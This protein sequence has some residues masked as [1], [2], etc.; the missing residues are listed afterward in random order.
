MLPSLTSQPEERDKLLRRLEHNA[1]AREHTC[2][3]KG[4][5]S[6]QRDELQEIYRREQHEFVQAMHSN[7]HDRLERWVNMTQGNPLH[8]D[9]WADDQ[10]KYTDFRTRDKAEQ[11]RR[12][13]AERRR[14][15]AHQAVL[16][17]ATTERDEVTELRA[18]RRMLVENQKQLKAIQDVERSNGRF[19][20]V[21]QERKK[22]EFDKQ[23]QTLLRAVSSPGL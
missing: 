16:T 8:V 3:L 15:E 4:T 11:I 17:K 14:R 13:V 10:K 23:Q 20:K 18:E 7:N 22:A 19:M 9:Q 12:K 2:S 5:L 21:L 1:R 6:A